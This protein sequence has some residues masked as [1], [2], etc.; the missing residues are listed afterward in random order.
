MTDINANLLLEV[1]LD[2]ANSLNN[3][4]RFE[5]LLST[6][7]KAIKCDAVALLGL[8]ENVLTPWRYKGLPEERL[9]A[10]L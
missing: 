2:L 4:D 8:N 3:S 7:R 9:A 10:V 1:A 6:I 5:R